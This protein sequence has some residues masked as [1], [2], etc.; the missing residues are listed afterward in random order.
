MARVTV[1]DCVEVESNR[2]KL[3][4]CASKRAREIAAGAQLTV[5]RDHDK[6]PVIALREIAERTVSVAD[7]EESLIRGM[8]R[9]FVR[10]ESE[11]D[12][13]GEIDILSWQDENEVASASDP[14]ILALAHVNAEAAV[15]EEEAMEIPEKTI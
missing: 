6:N 12:M 11:S 13:D 10:D 8:Q 5:A 4:L 14:D 2:F 3:I 7:I 9:H 15:G 1:E